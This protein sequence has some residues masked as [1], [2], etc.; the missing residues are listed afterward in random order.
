VIVY[1]VRVQEQEAWYARHLPLVEQ[2]IV[3][4]GANVGRLSQFFWDQGKRT[5]TIVSIEPM[6]ENV[7]A[8]E[9]R[10]RASRA[11]SKWT[12]KRCAISS[13]D[14]HVKMRSVEQPWG[15]NSVVDESERGTLTIACRRLDSLVPDATVVKVD[16]EGHEHEFLPSAVPKMT[17]VR[18]WA[19][20][21]HAKP[22]APLEPTLALFADA[23]FRLL[24]AGT[25]KD[26]PNGPWVDVEVTP[27]WSWE[28]VASTR[29]KSGGTF[30][31]LH[32]LALRR[33]Q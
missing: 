21:L 32:L 26:D 8:I 2:R 20:E 10:I 9:A 14:G 28:R 13:R 19:V 27:E 1:W 30:K 33:D 31:M 12:V 16:V 22:G 29:M 11:G 24:T 17:S 3:D 6:P 25:T 18:A 15:L 7:K 5:S 23:G 4:V